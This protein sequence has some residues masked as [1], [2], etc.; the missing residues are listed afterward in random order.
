MN[1][2]YLAYGLNCNTE[3]YF[4]RADLDLIKG[5]E[6]I[7]TLLAKHGL[8][9]EVI[10]VPHLNSFTGQPTEYFDTYRDDTK[11][12]LGAGLTDRYHVIQ[13]RD[14]MAALEDIAAL[15]PGDAY[16]ARGMTF[17][18]GRV[19]VAQID[20]GDMQ[21][22]E[23]RRGFKD[24][25]R[26]YLTWTNSHDGSGSA[27][28]FL[29]PVRI[30]CANTLTAALTQT[31]SKK[32]GA[33]DA[34]SKFSIRHTATAKE[35]LE[36][37]RKTLRVVNGE[38]IR[39][40]A[41][42]QT[43][44]KAVMPA[45]LLADVLEDLFSTEGKDKQA[46]KNAKESKTRA[47]EYIRNADD[48]KIDPSTVW[49]AYQGINR[50]LIHDSPIRIHGEDKSAGAMAHSRTQSTLIG[51]IAEKNARA[52]STLIKYA[53]I[54]DD[55]SRILKSVETSQA[56]TLATYAPEAMQ[57]GSYDLFSIDVGV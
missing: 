40:E 2:G 38:L 6:S 3:K 9:Y 28:L 56:A 30:V 37:A 51:S 18:G 54:E 22:G 53:E 5:A 41:T 31:H 48:G 16:F 19:A 39:T 57:Q 21:I 42:Y 12:I 36:E 20:L 32:K 4:D 43:M 1:N 25:V 45:D 55:I 7:E 24:M 17:D 15:F 14:N 47:V 29:S 52:L 49:A 8:N 27:H 50:L 44:A 33:Q 46:I 10:T 34:I 13:N 26:K 11:A 35:R 23:G